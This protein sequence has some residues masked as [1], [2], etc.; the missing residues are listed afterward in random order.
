MYQK[1]MAIHSLP[2]SLV[3]LIGLISVGIVSTFWLGW[4][5]WQMALLIVLAWLPLFF[6]KTASIYRQYRWLALFFI[7][8]VTQGAHFV[9]HLAQM[10]QLHLLGLS[11]QQASGIFGMLN[12]EWVHFIWNTWV[13]LFV[14]LLLYFFRT[15]PW[16]WVLLVVS[17]WHELEHVYIMAVLLRTG[18]A[19]TPGLLAQGGALW[20]GLPIIR[21]DLHFLYNLAEEALLLIAYVF[22]IHR[23]DPVKVS[24]NLRHVFVQQKR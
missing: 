14:L 23:I 20:G 21:A 9:E 24:S 5:L 8:V 22:Q 11:G 10:I 19:G 12:L 6:L 3:V 18:H 7:L 16:L 1:M 2:L 4:A 13:L 15:N 17:A